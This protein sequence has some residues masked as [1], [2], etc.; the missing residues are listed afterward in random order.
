VGH[1]VLDVEHGRQL[2]R[3]PLAV[4]EADRGG[5]GRAIDVDPDHPAGRAAGI[6]DGDH[7]VAARPAD[8]F[9][10]FL[11]LAV[12]VGWALHEGLG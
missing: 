10:Q 7:V 4:V 6:L 11:E 8:R 5:R 12:D 1:R 2:A 9:H 3:Q